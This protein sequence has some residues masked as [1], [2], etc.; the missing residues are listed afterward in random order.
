MDYLHVDFH[1]GIFYTS[2]TFPLMVMDIPPERTHRVLVVD[3]DA[4]FREITYLTLADQGYDV[5]TARNGPEALAATRTQSYDLILLDLQMPGMD[6]KEVLRVLREESP[7]SDVMMVT[8]Y[9]DVGI[10]V[11]LIKLGAREYITKPFEPTDFLQRVKSALRARE[12]EA[13]LRAAQQEFTSRLLYDLRTPLLTM[14]SSVDVLRKNMAGPTTEQQQSLLGN[15]LDTVGNLTTLLN[16]MIDLSVFESGS[17]ELEKLPTNLDELIPGVCARFMP[18][19]HAKK[20]TFDVTVSPDVP[21]VEL[22]AEKI[23]Q[24]MENL[25]DNA[26]KYTPE[27]GTI[28][29]SVAGMEKQLH[30]K[31]CECVEVSVRDSGIGIAEDELM[32]IFDK[33]KE[34][35]TKKSSAQRTTGL[36]LAICRGIVEAHRG[37][38]AAVSHPGKGSTF[39]FVLPLNPS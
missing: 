27:G 10:A 33:Y 18:Q 34:V 24:V 13:R 19:S 5:H 6:G 32:L 36:G 23:T 16:D 20:I 1:S 4:G 12:A 38:M 28:T 8:G 31:L 21:T 17:V 25:L 11:E 2:S 3:D 14:R 39:S 37:A 30:G 29:V 22:D 15:I 9:R 26:I 35:L 7:L